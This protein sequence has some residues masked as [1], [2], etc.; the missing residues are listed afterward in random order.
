MTIAFACKDKITAYNVLLAE[1]A[2]QGYTLQH[3][4]SPNCE[5]V[6][7]LYQDKSLEVVVDDNPLSQENCKLV[8]TRAKKA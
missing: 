4:G 7:R 6:E 3:V 1:R 5:K 8:F 2:L